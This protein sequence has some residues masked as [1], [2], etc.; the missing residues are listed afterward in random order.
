MM[1]MTHFLNIEP[2]PLPILPTRV[3]MGGGG[4]MKRGRGNTVRVRA[5]C[6]GVVRVRARY[7]G[8]VRVRASCQ[9]WA[10]TKIHG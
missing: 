9:G 8:G 2:L 6:G 3:S 4:V 10:V 5:G 1:T 7:K